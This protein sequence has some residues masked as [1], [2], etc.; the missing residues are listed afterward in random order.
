MQPLNQITTKYY[1]R[2]QLEIMAARDNKAHVVTEALHGIRQIKFSATELQW[3]KRI[4]AAREQELQAQWNV[5]ICGI[6]LTFG[7]IAMPAMMG[8]AAMSV[9]AYSSEQMVPSVAFTALSIFS[10]LEW[11]VGVVPITITE[12][13]DA[14]VSAD[15]IQQHL[16]SE[17]RLG[18]LKQGATVEFKDATIAWPSRSQSS[19][20]STLQ[21]LNLRFPPDELR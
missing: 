13:L 10:S 1:T 11:T 15:R 17:E 8:A 9:Y 6:F 21:G 5:Y 4:L 2:R 20:H 3:E 7:W 14:R 16:D 18:T 19:Q 12:M